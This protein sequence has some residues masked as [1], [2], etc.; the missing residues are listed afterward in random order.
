[1]VS[2]QQRGPRATPP[3]ATH[4]EPAIAPPTP[5]S[6]ERVRQVDGQFN[7][8]FSLTFIVSS[9]TYRTIFLSDNGPDI[10]IQESNKERDARLKQRMCI[11]NPSNVG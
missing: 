10:M 4:A 11:T 9:R 8:L 3:R 1:M 7:V 5:E 6:P 2:S